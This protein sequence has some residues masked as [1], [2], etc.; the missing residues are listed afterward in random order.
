MFFAMT[1]EEML[2]KYS[3]VDSQENNYQ[4]AQR[5]IKEAMQHGEKYV[6][7][8]KEEFKSE[9]TWYATRETIDRLSEDGFDIN[10]VWQPWEY[11]SI[12]WYD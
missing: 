1:K 10:K 12:E 4:E 9:F 2:Q 11:N 5:R 6:L 8:P 7:L 3:T